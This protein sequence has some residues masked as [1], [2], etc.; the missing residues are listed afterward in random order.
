ME[1]VANPLRGRGI[2]SLTHLSSL[3]IDDPARA[4]DLFRL[5]PRKAATELME[6]LQLARLL[7]AGRFHIKDESD[8]MG[9]GSFKALGA[10]HSIARLAIEAR[11][12]GASDGEM[13]SALAGRVFV[14]ASAGNH[15]LSVAAGAQVFGADAII[16]VSENVPET[17]AQRLREKGAE[18]RRSGETYEDSLANAAGEAEVNGLT[19]LSDSSW[20]GYYD[21]PSSVMEGY[22]ISGKEVVDQIP[23][24]PSHI[25]LQ[26][27]VGGFAASMAALF[28]RTW[29]DHPAI[30]VV[31][32]VAARCVMESVV[33]G[34]PVVSPGPVSS[35]GRLDCKEASHL[36]LATLSA[37]ADFFVTIED[38]I[39]ERAVREV[40][41]HGLRTTPSGVAGIAGALAAGDR[42]GVSAESR[43]L[44]FVTEGA[45]GSA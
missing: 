19:L 17:F 1:V 32:P 18:V 5:C 13:A 20:D 26:A 35:M 21:L 30:I 7:G 25:F 15:G 16:Y 42:L 41:R 37:E 11:G 23:E 43:C 9:L 24:T 14:C 8:R 38:Q 45:M 2:P 4:T 39:A 44:A 31:E 27:G 3:V 34:S 29:G 10:F 6:S 33:A 28:R 12:P 22:L 36:A 40:S